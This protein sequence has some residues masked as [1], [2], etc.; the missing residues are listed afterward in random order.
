MSEVIQEK[1]KKKQAPR[2]TYHLKLHQT[3]LI[4]GLDNSCASLLF[5]TCRVACGVATKMSVVVGLE[6]EYCVVKRNVDMKHQK[7]NSA[8]LRRL[9]STVFKS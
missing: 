4:C 2:G 3:A 6:G 9:G 7:S 8:S 5:L 1:K